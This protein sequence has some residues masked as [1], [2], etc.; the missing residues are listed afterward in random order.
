[1]NLR[2]FLSHTRQTSIGYWGIYVAKSH[3][4][5]SYGLPPLSPKDTTNNTQEASE[6]SGVGR[7]WVHSMFSRNRAVS[8]SR[9]G[10]KEIGSP[11]KQDVSAIA[12]KKVQTTI[13]VLRGHSGAV[14]ALH[15]VTKKEVWD[16]VGE[17]DDA[18]F[19]ISGSTDCTILDR[20]ST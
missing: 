7:S 15:C 1:I 5:S 4:V 10:A 14:T 6:E 13:R 16:L 17:R 2:G 12:Q 19:F 20:R 18:G 11:R 3:S 9:G 8:F